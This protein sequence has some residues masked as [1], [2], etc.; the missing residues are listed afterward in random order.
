VTDLALPSPGFDLG[1]K[2]GS[3]PFVKIALERIKDIVFGDVLLAFVF[4]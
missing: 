1:L 3:D 2:F 4:E